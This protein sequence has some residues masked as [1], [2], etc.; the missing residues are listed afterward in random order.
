MT[1]PNP[2]RPEPWSLA[3]Q[4]GFR[5]AFIY[6]VLYGVP[7]I[8]SELPVLSWL[9]EKYLA[10]WGPLVSA[11]G[12]LLLGLEVHARVPNGSGDQ[13]SSYVEVVCLLLVSG[14]GTVAWSLVDRK[15]PSYR[16][17]AE[18]LRIYLR[19]L[20]AFTMLL[21]GLVKVVKSQ[22]PEPSPGRLLVPIGQTSPMGLLWTFMGHSTVYTVFAG[23]AEVSGG[24][25]LL[26]RRTT[27]LGSL[28]LIGVL[29]HVVVLN[30]SYDVP[31]KLFSTHL[32]LIAAY[33][34]APDARRMFDFLVRNRPTR[35][36]ELGAPPV[37][38]TWRRP[39]AI[40]KAV[41]VTGMVLYTAYGALEAY[42]IFG[43]GAARIPLHGAY[44]VLAM[45]KDGAP[46]APGDP[47]VWRQIAI[48]RVSFLVVAGDGLITRHLSTWDSQRGT[49]SVSERDAPTRTGR[50]TARE[51]GGQ[52]QLEGEL[53]GHTLSVRARRIE[54]SEF[55]LL[56]RGFHWVSEEPFNR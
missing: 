46:T 38:P 45:E 36:A 16:E 20:L 50:L 1:P 9:G 11:V 41:A 35:P 5:F 21:Y 32:L 27:A 25:L 33:L 18:L 55:L 51:A 12:D 56:R 54:E 34:F 26:F 10:L 2:D 30:Y 7:G 42:R 6:L 28:V 49:L 14:L 4:I 3:R 44:Q 17:L 23:L 47:T 37:P 52:L 24:A 31:V 43:D 39:L 48:S 19:Y 13:L 15:R 29:G 53:A 40:V 22:F 8:M